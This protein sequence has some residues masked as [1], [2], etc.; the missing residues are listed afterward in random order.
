MSEDVRRAALVTGASRGIGASVAIRLA[1]DGFAVAGCYAVPSPAA[2]KAR[3]G[4]EE[5]G[6]AA[7][8]APCDVRDADAVEAFVTAAE[9]AIGPIDTLVANAGIVRDNPMVLMPP[10]DWQAVVDTNLTGTWNACRAIG[11][12]LMKRDGGTIVTVSSV[13]GVYG[14]ASQGNYAAAKAGI[15]GLSRSLARELARFGVRV[16]CVAPGF[17]ETD[18]T[19]GMPDRLR[20]EALSRIPLGRF[21]RP[22]DVA[23][24]IAFLVSDRA[25]YVT[26]QV[27]QVDGGIRL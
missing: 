9:R 7:F 6:Q 27:I 16:N 26:D 17:I 18:M 21:G 23:E 12:R 5:L 4:V 24:M 10:E 11:Y 14:N 8:F 1:A 3:A 25:A 19:D 2:D 15:I 13:A 22:E 20:K